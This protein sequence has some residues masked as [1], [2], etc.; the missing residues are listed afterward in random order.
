MTT[1]TTTSAVRAAC[2]WCGQ[3]FDAKIVG[4]NTKTFCGPDCKGAFHTALRM[5]AQ[6][7]LDDGRL[8]IA[9]LKAG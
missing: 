3:P 9:D 8:S 7:A 4:V 6:R 1:P 2:R 5:W